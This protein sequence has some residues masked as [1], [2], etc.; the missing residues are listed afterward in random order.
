MAVTE[1]KKPDIILIEADQLTAISLGLYGN[2]VV[3]TPTLER[4]AQRGMLFHRAYCN[5]PACAP[6]R[7][8]MMTGRYTST[9]RN[10]ANHMLLNPEEISI[11][12]CLRRAG[13]TTALIG[14]NH[15]FMDGRHANYY[16]EQPAFST[17]SSSNIQHGISNVQGKEQ[18][19]QADAPHPAARHPTPAPNEILRAFDHLVHGDHIGVDG[20]DSDAELRASVQWAR[21][22]CW[23]QQHHFGKNPY[24]A[25]KSVT[26]TLTSAACDYVHAMACQDKPYFLWFSIP[27][28]HTPYQVSEPYASMYDPE[29]MPAPIADNLENKPERQRIAH[30]LDHNHERD[31]DHFKALRAI[32]Y[33][34]INQIDDN[35]ARLFDAL[36]AEGRLENTLIVF[37]ADHGDAMGDHGIIQK[38]NFFYDSICR[39]PFIISQPGRIEPGSS[40]RL[41]ELVDLMPTLLDLAGVP[42]PHGVQGQSLAPLLQGHACLD[43]P[44]IVIESGEQGEP[45]HLADLYDDAG[46][47]VD[48][49]TSFAWCAFREAWL[50]RGKCLR[51]DRWKLCVYT[52]GEGE[53][54]DMREDPGEISNLYGRPEYREIEQELKEQLLLW[55]MRNQDTIPENRTVGLT[56]NK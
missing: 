23:G 51:T 34:M 14:K 20:M 47:L 13:Y 45:P 8:S 50:G 5:Y 41:V 49:G 6:S 15:C 10:H 33:G 30:L 26:Y 46:N 1:M 40:D 38:H 12:L 18:G 25:E 21:E 39:V 56:L 16:P 52:N 17:E 44:C 43:K 48:K 55:C 31:V 2:P 36:E 37:T 24:P 27:D 54:Y 42:V 4:F 32:H 11:P 28:P 3:K 53:L 35:L 22:N 19:M 9:L 7:C 29:Q